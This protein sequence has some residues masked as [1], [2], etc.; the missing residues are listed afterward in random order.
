MAGPE[1]TIR[2]E[3]VWSVLDCPSGL[4][5]M[6]L[7]DP[8]AVNVLGRLTAMLPGPIEAGPTYVAAGWMIERAGRKLHTGSATFTAAGEPLAWARAAWIVPRA[9]FS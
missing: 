6:L 8:P 7:P 5:P 1:G 3:L 4:A 2:P 9:A